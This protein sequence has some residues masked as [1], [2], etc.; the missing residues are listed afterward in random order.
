MEVSVPDYVPYLLAVLGLLL[1]WQLHQIQVR[2]GRIKAENFWEQ[3]GIRMFIFIAP[4]DDHACQ[5]CQETHGLVLLPALRAKKNFSPLRGSCTNASGCRCQLIGLNGAWPQAQR[6]LE[7]L[8]K[9]KAKRFKLSEKNI[10]ALL[11]GPWQTD[12]KA[13]ID[14]YSML[15]VEAMLMETKELA[16]AIGNYRFI[17][18]K[19]KSPRDM[20]LV[21]PAYMRLIELYERADQPREGTELIAQMEKRFGSDGSSQATLSESQQETLSLTK[22]RLAS[23]Q[24]V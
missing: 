14:Q 13:K 12:K 5:R 19:A 6:V 2:A 18:E 1:I 20:P 15:M 4:Q 8:Q 24:R 9:I 3:S 23:F 16:T 21:I 10:N 11:K 22:T 17:I 7:K